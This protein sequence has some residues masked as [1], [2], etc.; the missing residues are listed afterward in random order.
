M[1]DGPPHAPS[2]N[3]KVQVADQLAA[4]WS[5]A[6]KKGRNASVDSRDGC[7]GRTP[8]T[9]R[10]SD[11]HRECRDEPSRTIRPECRIWHDALPLAAPRATCGTLLST[12]TVERSTDEPELERAE[13]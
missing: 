9:L 7:I 13:I 1:S 11:R 2:N 8:S 12:S 3:P 10:T 6:E 4:A 5:R